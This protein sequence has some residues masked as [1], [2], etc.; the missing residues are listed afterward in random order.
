[1]AY[2]TV[3]DLRRILPEKVQIGDSNIG[4]P[5]PGRSGAQGATRS[6]ISPSESEK[7]IL[8]AQQYIDARLRPFYSCPL[9]K[10]KSFETETLNDIAPGTDVSVTM[11]DT[12]SFIIGDNV[13]LQNKQKMET[14]VVKEVNTLT[15][16]T[17]ESVQNSYL[18]VENSTISIIEYPDPI[19][20][21]AARLACSFILDRLFSAEQ[22]PDVSN[23]GKTQRN[24]AR[25]SI[26]DILSGTALLFGQEHTGRRFVRS[27]LLD[28]LDSPGTIQKGE[29]K[30]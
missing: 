22:A 11:Y 12:G 10:I 8:Y 5:V 3:D 21:V 23:Y 7:Y 1:M 18:V 14:S 26:D 13:R 24:L 30:E 19:P 28:R 20:I 27:S 15:Q 16:L 9:R 6:N 25:N 29:E 17:L 2:C 4:R